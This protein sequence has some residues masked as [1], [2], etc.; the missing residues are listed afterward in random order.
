MDE[1]T[2]IDIRDGKII[3]SETGSYTVL[4]SDSIKKAERVLQKIGVER[5]EQINPKFTD[6]IPIFRLNE[7]PIKA[8]CHRQACQWSLP[9]TPLN[10]PPRES[11]G[12][13]MTVEQS[14][15]SAMMEA[16]ERY[17]GQR[18][19]HHKVVNASYEEV[20]DYAIHPSEFNFPTLPLKCENCVARNNGCFQVLNGFQEW[21]WGYSLVNKNPVLI[22]SALVYYPYISSSN[23]SFMFND[24]GGLSAGNILEEAILQGIAEVIE[25][26]ALYYA[27]NLGNLRGMPMLNVKDIKSR[28]IQEFINKVPPERIFALHIKNENFKI[29]IPTV[30][31][32]IC[33][34]VRNGRYY[35]GGSGTSLNPEVA[36]LRALTELE[37]QKVRQ[38]AF[39]EFD[40]NYLVA[41]NSI[42][43]EEITSVPNQ[44]TS[45]IKG[46]IELYLDRLSKNNMDVVVVDLTHPEIRIP[47][48]RI[49]IP[50]L[51]SYSG[52]PIK[53]SVLLDAVKAFGGSLAD[54]E[55]I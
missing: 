24:T 35:F 6:G 50:K 54:W 4:P 16:I 42:E 10:N 45:N 1:L 9:P 3:Y 8:K 32:F 51:I 5:I 2:R 41:H 30:S 49:V 13:G 14:K 21:N 48:V 17:C 44:S 43:L 46:D 26:D 47:V 23:I 27:F 18:F 11:F 36:L 22:P 12:K 20:Q 38:K 19:P 15:A 7:A 40:P 31:A 33:Y 52:S 25:R 53:E 55:A 29:D 34:R 37:Q 28:H 39:V